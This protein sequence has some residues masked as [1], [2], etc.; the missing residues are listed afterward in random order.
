MHRLALGQT[1]GGLEITCMGL[2]DNASR[3]PCTRQ[4]MAGAES[5]D[6]MATDC[7]G[8]WQVGYLPC[9]GAGEGSRL[10]DSKREGTWPSVLSS[11]LAG[12]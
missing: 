9:T 8:A 10:A 3:D 2:C 1:S 7:F 4:V 11:W 6:C 5:Y 12:S